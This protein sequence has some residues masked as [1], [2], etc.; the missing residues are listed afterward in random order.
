MTDT[1]AKSEN[2]AVGQLFES[3]GDRIYA[4]GL[5]MCGSP[6]ASGADG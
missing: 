4:M 1:S 3:H 5:R 6:D 2:E